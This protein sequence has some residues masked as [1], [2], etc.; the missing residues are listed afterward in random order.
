MVKIDQHLIVQHYIGQSGT[1]EDYIGQDAIERAL[2]GSFYSDLATNP[3]SQ[4]N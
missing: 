2:R 1:V 4:V 3:L